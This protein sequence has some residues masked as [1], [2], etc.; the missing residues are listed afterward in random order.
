M[1][2]H[3]DNDNDSEKQ[4]HQKNDPQYGKD[5]WREKTCG[6]AIG[7]TKWMLCHDVAFFLISFHKPLVLNH[8]FWIFFRMNVW[9][10]WP[11][12]SETKVIKKRVT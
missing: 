5:E 11:I 12:I 10:Y 9:E 1:D 6:G 4:H 2:T 7:R 3:D 8:H